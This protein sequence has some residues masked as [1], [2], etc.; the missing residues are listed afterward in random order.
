M[1]KIFIIAVFILIFK[2]SFA[3]KVFISE[4]I[5]PLV[6]FIETCNT[7]PVDYTMSLFEKYDIVILGERDHNDTTQYELI[8]DIISDTRFIN[9]V[10][11][12]LTEVGVYNMADELNE[13]LR[14]NY[15]NEDT[16]ETALAQIIFD[17]DFSPVWDKSNYSQ[18]LKDVYHVNRTL[19]EDKKLKVHP[20]E[21]PFSWRQAQTITSEEYDKTV[22]YLWEYKDII[23]GNNAITELYRI[24][25]G[26]DQRKKALIIY[27]AP[28]SCRYYKVKEK[29]DNFAAQLI[30]DRFPG[31]VANIALNWATVSNNGY[32]SLSNS[33]KID[34]AF[35]ACGNK[36]IGFNLAE[37]PIGKYLFDTGFIEPADSIRF[38]DVFNGFIFY[39][40]IKEWVLGIGMPYMNKINR[41]DELARRWNIFHEENDT[42]EEYKEKIFNYLYPV[43][44]IPM[45]HVFDEKNIDSQISQYYYSEATE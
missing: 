14:A 38:Q 31:R 12:I 22:N 17:L 11:H 8:K 6:D 7:S 45:T 39:K 42:S 5:R 33:G 23:M 13:V 9:N 2:M 24:F 3:Q 4:E 15:S 25:D 28:H 21:I 26:S 10:G 19:T 36:S 1:R 34:A 40:P 35:A 27:N 29:Y 43:R 32:K 16:F 30:I 37:S 41:Q 44:N 20:T 18:F